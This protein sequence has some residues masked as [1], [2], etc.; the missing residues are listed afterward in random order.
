MKITTLGMIL[1]F[2]LIVVSGAAAAAQVV[3]E[4]APAEHISRSP[5][6]IHHIDD[7]HTKQKDPLESYNRFMFSVNETLDKYIL[8]PIAE[9]YRKIMP[10][11]MARGISNMYSNIGMLPTTANDIL[12]GNFYQATSDAWRFAINSTIG[13]V[14]FYDV[15]SKIGLDPNHEDFGLTLARWG[16]TDSTYIVLPLFGPSTIRDTIGMPA[17]YYAFSIYSHMDNE[18]RR[19]AIYALGAVSQRAALLSYD[20]LRCKLG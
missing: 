5:D 14:G 20:D 12:Q 7:H 9:L 19:K 3:I 10:R 4:D 6:P 17:D 11:P 8:K 16:Y 18:E 2:A 15:G 13:I 1:V